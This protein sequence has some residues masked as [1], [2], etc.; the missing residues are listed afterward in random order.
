MTHSSFPAADRT[1]DKRKVSATLMK[2]AANK[3][4]AMMDADPAL[5]ERWHDQ[6][7]TSADSNARG[8]TVIL[9]TDYD[10]VIAFFIWFHDGKLPRERGGVHELARV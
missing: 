4:T 1:P 3:A 6:C 10:W 8:G 5:K 9:S 7:R 2:I